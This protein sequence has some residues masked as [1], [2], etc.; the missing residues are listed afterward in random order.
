MIHPCLSDYFQKAEQ[1]T[2]L[3]ETAL[4]DQ[5]K[6]GWAFFAMRGYLSTSW[7]EVEC[8]IQDYQGAGM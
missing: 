7:V 8:L 2:R 1:R 5:D 6:V 4:Q 3:L